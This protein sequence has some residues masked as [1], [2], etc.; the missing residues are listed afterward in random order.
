MKSKKAEPGYIYEIDGK[1][2]VN[3]NEYPQKDDFR[4]PTTGPISVCADDHRANKLWKDCQY[5]YFLIY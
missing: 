4:L 3:E 2:V 5:L 1:V